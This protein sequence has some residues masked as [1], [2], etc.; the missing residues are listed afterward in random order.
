M[1]STSIGATGGAAAATGRDGVAGTSARDVVTGWTGWIGFAASMLILIGAFHAVAGFVALFKDQYFLV[2]KSDLVV[3][4]NY[5]TWGWIHLGFGAVAILTGLGMLAGKMW[6]RV[7]GVIFAILSAV[8]N[9][10][11]LSA[12]PVWSTMIIAFDV[13]LIWAL[14]VHGREMEYR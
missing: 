10:G 13:L 7:V 3:T 2:T 12:Y 9:L 6:A 5:T 11:F 4:A 1:A 14:T 8:V